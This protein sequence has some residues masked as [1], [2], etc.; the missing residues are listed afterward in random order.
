[1]VVEVKLQV[2]QKYELLTA[3]Q[4]SDKRFCWYCGQKCTL[5]FIEKL[6]CILQHFCVKLGGKL[7]RRKRLLGVIHFLGVS[8]AEEDIMGEMK[9]HCQLYICNEARLMRL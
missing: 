8:S 3:S 7:R 6:L 4:F 2:Q 9:F 5:S 1:M